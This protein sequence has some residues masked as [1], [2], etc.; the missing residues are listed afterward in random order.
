VEEKKMDLN[1]AV[2]AELKG[3]LRAA[4]KTQKELA[5]GIGLHEKTVGRY[6]RGERDID[7]RAIA[8]MATVLNFEPVELIRRADARMKSVRDAPHN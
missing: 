3:Y 6:L 4:G 1:A 5:T 7:M 8:M 2:I